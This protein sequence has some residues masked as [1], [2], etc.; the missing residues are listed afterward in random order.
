MF[1]KKIGRFRKD[2]VA[3]TGG[4]FVTL[5]PS[6]DS[7]GGCIDTQLFSVFIIKPDRDS[8]IVQNQLFL[9]IGGLDGLELVFPNLSQSN[10]VGHGTHDVFIHVGESAR[11]TAES[12]YKA[13]PQS[14]LDKDRNGNE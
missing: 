6:G 4:Y 12:D 2:I 9:T 11:L 5:S 14:V 1:S 13:T 7:G 8:D 10:D 3:G